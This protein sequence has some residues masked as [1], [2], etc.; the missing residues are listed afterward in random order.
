M[1]DY[2]TSIASLDPVH[3]K[4]AMRVVTTEEQASPADSEHCQVKAG[5]PNWADENF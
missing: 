1:K 3:W 4:D 2:N 5:K